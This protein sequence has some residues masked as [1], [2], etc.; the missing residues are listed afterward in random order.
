MQLEKAELPNFLIDEPSIVSVCK[1]DTPS[2]EYCGIYVIVP[3]I[4]KFVQLL[5]AV[6]VI[7]TTLGVKVSDVSLVQLVN[8]K[9]PNVATFEPVIVTADKSRQAENELAGN[10]AMVPPIVKFVQLLNA[11]DAIDTT[12]GVKLSDVSLVQSVNAKAPNVA[13]ESLIIS[14]CKA[15]QPENELAGN[16]TMPPPIVRVA[17]FATVPVNAPAEIVLRPEGK[18]IF[19]KAEQLANTE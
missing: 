17:V 10:D 12:V 5:N 9:A 15:L 14:P 1:L 16:V 11:L 8:A 4:V 7:D 2:N 13:I 19:V 3:P 18:L 6:G